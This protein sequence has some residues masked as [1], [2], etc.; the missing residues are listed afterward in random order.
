MSISGKENGAWEGW[1]LDIFLFWLKSDICISMYIPREHDFW[2]FGRAG[3]ALMIGLASSISGFLFLFLL[4]FYPLSL[5]YFME[6]G[7]GTERNG[8]EQTVEMK[9]PFNLFSFGIQRFDV[10]YFD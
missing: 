4:F 9:R 3:G 5:I 8:R 7:K 6:M 2:S 1:I 10:C